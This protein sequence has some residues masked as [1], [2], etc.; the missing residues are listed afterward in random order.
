MRG[1]FVL[2]PSRCVLSFV[3]LVLITGCGTQKSS[4]K[5]PQTRKDSL[6]TVTVMSSRPAADAPKAMAIDTPVANEK[7]LASQRELRVMSFNLRVATIIDAAN[8]WN[9]R[10]D[11]VVQT[12]REFDP[13]ILGTQEGL[14]SQEDFL[15][16]CLPEYD[17]VGV[18]REN[19]KRIGEMCGVFYKTSRFTKVD[20][21][22]FWLSKKPTEPGSKSWGTIFPRMVTWVML[23]PTDGSEPIF[24]FNTHFDAW[25]GKARVESAKILRRA[26]TEIAGNSPC[27]VTGDFNAD[28]NSKPHQLMLASSSSAHQ[29]AL[30]D[31]FLAA[32]PDVTD[33]SD[34]TR[35]GFSGSVNGPRIDWILTTPQFS[36]QAASIDRNREK[37]RY[38]S[39]HFP[40]TAVLTR[41]P[42]QQ[43]L[44]VASVSVE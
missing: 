20:E 7:S 8:H 2:T 24:C 18:G 37:S 34:G 28:E 36:T 39:D 29:P 31:T 40:V 10:K 19:G 14:A 41:V 17:F 5:S 13:D 9:F 44:P 6:A 3:I 15:Q 12:I 4:Q 32:N 42:Q 23:K 1:F 11:L 27:I 25:G 38:P 21:G 26:M 33:N 30:T 16:S 43:P 35:H 22:H